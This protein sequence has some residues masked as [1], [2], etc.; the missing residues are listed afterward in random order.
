[1]AFRPDG[2]HLDVLGFQSIHCRARCRRL[3][4]LLSVREDCLSQTSKVNREV[5]GLAAAEVEETEEA[6]QDYTGEHEDMSNVF[7]G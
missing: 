5:Q 1:M 2:A 7:S 4:Y 3:Q 6:I